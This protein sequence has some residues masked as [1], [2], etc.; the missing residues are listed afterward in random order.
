MESVGVQ[1]GEEGGDD[2]V[3]E[4][5]NVGSGALAARGALGWQCKL[6]FDLLVDLGDERECD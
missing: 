5:L 3:R 6:D 1:Q 2:G 4:Y